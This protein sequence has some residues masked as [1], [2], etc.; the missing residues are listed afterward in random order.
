MQGDRHLQMVALAPFSVHLHQRV[1]LGVQHARQHV[2]ARAGD[3]VGRR[4]RRQAR[5]RA[6]RRL[7]H[8]HLVQPELEIGAVMGRRHVAV[9]LADRD[10]V[11]MAETGQGPGPP[12]QHGDQGVLA[13]DAQHG[14]AGRLPLLI[15]GAPVGRRGGRRGAGRHGFPL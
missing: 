2:V 11:V 12:H 1:M 5:F 13:V 8:R 7:V 3:G 4:L 9:E 6:Q 15:G 10:Q 14:L